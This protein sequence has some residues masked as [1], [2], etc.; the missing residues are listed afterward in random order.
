MDLNLEKW[1]GRGGSTKKESITA[2]IE[3]EGGNLYLNLVLG[4]YSYK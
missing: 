1:I 4:M 3:E 2:L